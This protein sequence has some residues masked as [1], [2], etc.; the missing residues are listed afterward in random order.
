M[1]KEQYVWLEKY[2]PKTLSDCILPDRIR[3]VAEKFIKEGNMQSLLLVGK[4]SAGKTTFAKALINDLDANKIIINGSKEGRYI[5]TLNTSL[6]EFVKAAS[7]RTYKAPFKVVLLDEADYLNAN[8][9][10][11]ALRNFIE[12]YSKT[13]RFILTCNYPYKILEPI[14]T[15][16]LEIDF[17]LKPNEIKDHR[18]AWFHRAIQILEEENIKVN[19]KKDV[20]TIVKSYYPDSRAILHALQQFSIDGVL[21]M[22]EKGLPGISRVDE[23]IEMLK[24]RNFLKLREWMQENP[25]E[26]ITTI[27]QAIYNRITEILSEDSIAEFI[28]IADEHDK[29]QATSTLPWLNIMAFFIKIMQNL[30]FKE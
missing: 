14:R 23:A 20:A 24:S 18:N 4:P 10:Q 26:T 25:Q 1:T 21:Q 7:S 29:D 12:T 16:L 13:T 27:T 9:F 30:E 15:R 8:S 11:P 17:D 6:D 28:L 3:K 2:R 22:P 5:D 19:D